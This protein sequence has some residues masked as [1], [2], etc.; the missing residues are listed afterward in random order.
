[1]N[2][3]RPQAICVQTLM[4]HESMSGRSVGVAPQ[5]DAAERAHW[6][7]SQTAH[8][9]DPP[10]VTARKE[11]RSR[12]GR[13][14][15]ATTAQFLKG[16]QIAFGDG[17]RLWREEERQDHI[18]LARQVL[19]RMHQPQALTDAFDPRMRAELCRRRA[20]LTSKDVELSAAHK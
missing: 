4:T 14:A 11:L 8:E 7:C 16:V 19:K 10:S 13:Q 6:A 9:H 1:M 17:D 2:C 5:P 18:S 20:W 3:R 15:M 12:E